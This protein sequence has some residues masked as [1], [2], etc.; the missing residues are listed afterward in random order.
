MGITPKDFAKAVLL[1]LG[2]PVTENNLSALVVWMNLEG[3]HYAN[4]AK[5]NPL[6]TTQGMPGSYSPKGF[7]VNI[8]SYL[9]W[10]QG[11]DATIKTLKYSDYQSIRQ[12]LQQSLDPDTTLRIINKTPWGTHNYTGNWQAALS[13]G[14]KA[15]PVGGELAIL[16]SPSS[17]SSP[18]SKSVFEYVVGGT[19]VGTIVYYV[20]KKWF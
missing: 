7:K 13:Y 19:V 12:A 11:L 16:S 6:N 17:V 8:Q 14:S 10:Q 1:T 15:D 5:F 2:Y 18:G 20:W 4:G 9:N 3:G